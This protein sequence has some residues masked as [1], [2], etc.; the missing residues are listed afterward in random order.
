MT[1]ARCG[2]V[3]RTDTEGDMALQLGEMVPDFT[4]QTTDG[5]IN[6]HQWPGNSWGVLFSHPKD[7]AAID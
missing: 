7:R 5:Q 3:T 2:N 4:A 6:F 1:P